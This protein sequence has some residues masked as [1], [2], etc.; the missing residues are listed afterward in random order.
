MILGLQVF[1]LFRVFFCIGGPV[2]LFFAYSSIVF[3]IPFI[4]NAV[5]SLLY[6][7]ASVVTDLFLC[8][9]SAVSDSL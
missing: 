7:L 5:F 2:S 3:P 6:I 4:E 8:A 9:R 1:N